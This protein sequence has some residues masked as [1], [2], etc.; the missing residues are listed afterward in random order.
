MSAQCPLVLQLR[1]YRC[2]AANVEM[3]HEETHAL[4]QSGVREAEAR[5]ILKQVEDAGSLGI[6]LS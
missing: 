1:K 4:K 2:V 5:I 3:G 6:V